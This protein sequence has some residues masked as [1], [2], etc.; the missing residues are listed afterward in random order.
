M[1]NHNKKQ[2]AEVLKNKNLN[3][4]KTS[5]ASRFTFPLIRIVVEIQRNR[6]SNNQK[7]KSIT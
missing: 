4:K 1:E 3:Q 7:I 5:Q 2:E 6:S